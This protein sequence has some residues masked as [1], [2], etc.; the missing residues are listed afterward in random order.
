MTCDDDRP[1]EVAWANISGK[2]MTMTLLSNWWYGII[3]DD[4]MK[5]PGD[6]WYCE[7]II[8][9][10]KKSGDVSDRVNVMTNDDIIM[11]DQADTMTRRR[12]E[13]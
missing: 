4:V 11:G 6:D 12:K 8:S 7:K 1:E 3:S 9:D 5:R 2:L 13:H 10:V